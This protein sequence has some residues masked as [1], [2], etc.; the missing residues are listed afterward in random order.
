MSVSKIDLKKTDL[1]PKLVGESDLLK[2]IQLKPGVQAGSEGT[3][4]GLF[5]HYL[6]RDT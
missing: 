5:M 1:L 3:G 6:G 2:S 4:G